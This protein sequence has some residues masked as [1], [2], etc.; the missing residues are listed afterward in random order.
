ILQQLKET[1]PR[2]DAVYREASPAVADLVAK[3]LSKD[4]KQ[5]PQDAAELLSSI[6]QMCEGAAALIT[7]HPAPPVV[8]ASLVQT[9][10]L[11]WDLDASPE[12]LWPFVS[13]TEK[14]NRATGLAPV[15]FEI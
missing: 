11:A 6:E 3:C 9:Y 5:R 13:N 1:P 7:A 4:P 8:K 2:L 10:E 14:M 12:Q 15:R